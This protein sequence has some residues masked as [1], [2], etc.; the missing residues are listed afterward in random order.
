MNIQKR[1]KIALI[2]KG[3]PAMDVARTVGVDS[4]AVYHTISGK[5]KSKRI[6]KALC[7][8]TG[9]PYSIWKEIDEQWT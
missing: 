9:L 4:S 3:I 7:E 8:A 1:I 2:K 6:R 5:N